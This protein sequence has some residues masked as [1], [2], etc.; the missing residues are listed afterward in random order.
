MYSKYIQWNKMFTL[1]TLAKLQHDW[2]LVD[3]NILKHKTILQAIFTI[4]FV[5]THHWAWLLSQALYWHLCLLGN[6][7]CQHCIFIKET[8]FM[9]CKFYVLVNMTPQLRDSCNLCKKSFYLTVCLSV[10]LSIYNFYKINH[11]LVYF[12]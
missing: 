8:F 9:F 2:K 10:Y 7:I 6:Q 11:E 4:F 1:C 12:I 3:L 5:F